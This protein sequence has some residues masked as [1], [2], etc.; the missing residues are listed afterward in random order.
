VVGG[1]TTDYGDFHGRNVDE[2]GERIDIL[3][4]GHGIRLE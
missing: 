4:D 1:K 3:F 2:N